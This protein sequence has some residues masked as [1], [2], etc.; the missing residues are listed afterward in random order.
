MSKIDQKGKPPTLPAAPL[1]TQVKVILI[2]ALVIGGVGFAF[3]AVSLGLFMG[4]QPMNN[5]NDN[6]QYYTY[7]NYT[8]YNTN[9]NTT[10]IY[11]NATGQQMIYNSCL[12]QI[13]SLATLEEC[14]FFNLT[15]EFKTTI[16]IL[17]FKSDCSEAI[18]N[19]YIYYNLSIAGNS[20]R[21]YD[22]A[23]SKSP[24]SGFWYYGNRDILGNLPNG[25]NYVCQF[26]MYHNDGSPPSTIAF[27]II[28][29]YTIYL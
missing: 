28:V 11:N 7:N 24:V 6:S 29:G 25:T 26:Y 19:V 18:S 16:D 14:Y 21:Y 27:Q 12:F 17:L 13:P 10:Y 23:F 9:Y 15:L 20:S 4:T 2:S 5:Y 8:T 22:P 1:S 3:G